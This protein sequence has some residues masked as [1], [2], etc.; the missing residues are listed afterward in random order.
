MN[1]IHTCSCLLLIVLAGTQSHPVHQ[2]QG[3]SNM[4]VNH[5]SSRKSTS[6]ICQS[7]NQKPTFH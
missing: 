6:H 7:T 1:G 4:A 2:E 3:E 5:L